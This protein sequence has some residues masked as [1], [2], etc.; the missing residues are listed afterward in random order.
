MNP[1][2][3]DASL[4][5]SVRHRDRGRAATCGGGCESLWDKLNRA[6]VGVFLW[7]QN[8]PI[9]LNREQ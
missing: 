3:S 5:T 7:F 4:D 6:W 9:I 2:G 8:R 1:G